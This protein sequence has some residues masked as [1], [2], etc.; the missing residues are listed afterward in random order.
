MFTVAVLLYGVRGC[1]P[2][3]TYVTIFEI[4]STR[5]TA[6]RAAAG[7]S[8]HRPL[9]RPP[10]PK[11]SLLPLGYGLFEAGAERRQCDPRAPRVRPPAGLLLVAAP[12]A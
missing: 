2:K 4:V 12:V 5:C 1:A 10:V 11:Y 8:R 3:I 7:G 6:E 9:E